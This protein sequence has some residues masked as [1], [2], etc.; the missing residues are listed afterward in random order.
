MDMWV[1]DSFKY[2][3]LYTNGRKPM[4][5]ECHGVP[6]GFDFGKI[7]LNQASFKAEGLQG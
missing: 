3:T 4:W 5:M 7:I 1:S 2:S 6:I